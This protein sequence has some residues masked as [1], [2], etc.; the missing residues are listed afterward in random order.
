MY[1]CVKSEI[2]GNIYQSKV[3]AVFGYD[4]PFVVYNK[5]NNEGKTYDLR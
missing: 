3:Y 1:V 4:S 5:F 2:S